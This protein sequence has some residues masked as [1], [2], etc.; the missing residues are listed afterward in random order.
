MCA[1]ELF[2]LEIKLRSLLPDI[3]YKYKLCD[4]KLNV[5]IMNCSRIFNIFTEFMINI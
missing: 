4:L 2:H 3:R 1:L 5:L